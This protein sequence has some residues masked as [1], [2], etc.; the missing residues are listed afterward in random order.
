MPT[1]SESTEIDELATLIHEKLNQAAAAYFAD[2]SSLHTLPSTELLYETYLHVS[3][4]ES[5]R[6]VDQSRFFA[7]AAR[8][9]RTILVDR[10]RCRMSDRQNGTR[11]TV[12]QDAD[13]LVIDGTPEQVIGIHE[14]LDELKE[15]YPRHGELVELRYFGGLTET[16]AAQALGIA[17]VD[18]IKDWNFARLW[19]FHRLTR[20]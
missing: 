12:A 14:I 16:E 4:V 10:A 5:L 9:L 20:K 13:R 2:G 18:V 11:W 1:E 8:A 17:S 3:R 15:K 19:L 6:T 7:L